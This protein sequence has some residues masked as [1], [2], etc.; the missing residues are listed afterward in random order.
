MEF[1]KFVV[2]LIIIAKGDKFF[3]LL[4]FFAIV[5]TSF[6]QNTNGFLREVY[7]GI[8]G[9]AISDLTN[10]PSFPSS[11]S[12][13]DLLT[14]YFEAPTDWNDN[15]G[16]RVR[17]LII[18][19]MTG[20]YIFWIASDD[21]SQ[22][23]LS[24]D[25]NP[26]NKRLIASVNSWTSSREWTKEAN[27]QS[28]PIRL[29][30]GVRYYIEALQKE[31][32]GGDN[33]AVGWQ[34][35]DGTLERPIP[36]TRAIPY[37]LGPPVITQQ[38]KNTS[39][40]EGGVAT[41]SIQLARYIGMAFQWYRDGQPI[42]GANSYTYFF[43][44]VAM[45]DN[46]STY[47]CIVSNIFGGATSQVARLTVLADTTPPTIVSA[48][49][50]G[51]LTI[52]AVYFS[53]PVEAISATNAA[54]YVLNREAQV[55]S[56]RFGMNESSIILTTT[57]LTPRLT[58][59]LTVNN[60]RDRAAVP[61]TIARDSRVYFKIDYTPLEYYRAIPQI[62]PI[63]PSSRRSPIVISEVMYNPAQRADG[64]NL[65][66]IEI[67]NSQPWFEEIGGWKVMGSVEFTFPE[68]TIIQGNSF[69][70]IAANPSD[71][72]LVYNITNVFGPF[73]GN[74]TLPN[75][76]GVLQIRN[77]RNAVM[78]EMKYSDK[79]PYPCSADGAGH[80]LV[81]SNPSFGERDPRA[82]GQSQ[83]IGGSPG[84]NEPTV[85]NPYATVMINELYIDQFLN[86]Y[87]ELFNY[88]S[89]SVSLAGCILTDDPSTN[90]F[91]IP[92]N[93]IIRAYSFVKF[94]AAQLGFSLN[95]QGGKV[96][97]KNPSNTRVIDS[98]RYDGLEPGVPIGRFPDGARE[99]SRLKYD[100]P[101]TNNAPIL[102]SDIVINEIMY[103][104][105]T[106][107]KDEEY[108]EIYNN[109]SNAVNIGKWRL[110]GGITY[111]FPANA[112]IPPNGYFVV[113]RNVD[114]LL[115]TH[116]GLSRSI[117]FGDFDGSLSNEGDTITLDKPVVIAITNE[118]GGSPI[119]TTLHVVVDEVSYKPGGRWGK[120]SN[121]GGSSLERIDPRADGRWAYNWA[122]SDESQKSQWVTVEYTGV[123]DN[124]NGDSSALHIILM[125]PGECLV[126]NVEVL[127]N[128][129]NLVPNP[130]FDT[131]AAGWFFEGTHSYS[132]YQANGGV[133]GSGCLHVRATERGDTGANRILAPLTSGISA[134]ATATLRAKVRWLKGCGQ[135]LLRLKGNW[136]EA[137]GD[138]IATTDF[139]T[140]GKPNSRLVQNAGPAISDVS[141]Y[142]PVPAANQS[143]TVYA[144]VQDPD[145]LAALLLQYRVD[146]STNFIPLSMVNR[147]AGWYSATI[148]GQ[149]SGT[150]VAF[151]INA[152]DANLQYQEQSFF[153]KEAPE[154]ECLIR[155][156]DP[157]VNG[158]LGVY[159]FWISQ[160]T[161]NRWISRE[162][163]SNDPLDITFIYG[164]N[165]VI[166]N[167]G[168]E[169][170]GSPYHSPGYN[171]PI[172]NNCDYVITFPEDDRLL[173]ET[174]INLLQPGNGGGDSTLQAEQ[175]AYWIAAKMG[176]PI[177][178][179]R[180]V[181][182]FV[183]GVR[184]GMLFEDA[185]QP[186]RD[187]VEEW[188]PEDSKGDLH[189][190][191]LWFEFDDYAS[192]FSAVGANLGNYLTTG[193]QK[194]LARYRW[195]WSKRAFGNDGNNYTN[196][197]ALVDTVNTTAS[198][199]AYTRKIQSVI[200]VEQ[201]YKTH[202][203]EHIVGNNDSYSYGGGQNMYAYK[204]QRGLWNLLIWDIDFAFFAQ[205]PTSDLFGIGGRQSGPV[206]SHPPFARIYWQALIQAA[207]GPLQSSQADSILDARYNAFVADGISPSNPQ[208]I[209]NFIAARRNYILG[210]VQSNTFP[211]AITSNN[212]NGFSTNRNLVV[213]SGTAPLDVRTIAVNGIP[214]DA[215]WTTLSNWTI[216]AHLSPGVN[217]LN[218][219][220][221]DKSGNP[222]QSATAS[223]AIEYT[224]VDEPPKGNIVINEIMYNPVVP[225][226]SYIEVYNRS[227]N[228]AFD[229]SD[230]R[231]EGVD[232]TFDP[233]TIIEPNSY[234]VVVKDAA[235]FTSIY[236][237]SIPIAGEFAGSLN[238]SGETIRLIQPGNSNQTDVV[239]AA[240]TYGSSPPWYEAAN[241]LGSS[242][243]LI[244]PAQD[245]SRVANWGAAFV[246]T[247]ATA[248]MLVSMT[249]VWKYNQTG[250]L[251]GAGWE[252]PNYDDSSWASGAALLYVENAALPAQKNTPLT[253]GR[254]TYYFRKS[255][256]FNGNPSAVSLRL[257][258][259]IDDGA[260]IYLNGNRIYS[261]WMPGG[262]ITYSTFASSAVGDATLEGPIDLP[263]TYLQRGVNVIAV[264]VHQV[265]SGS[266]DIVFG[267]SLETKPGSVALATPGAANSIR[268]ALPQFPPIWLNEIQP[269]NLN[270]IVD[271][272]N[273]R[274][275]WVELYN[276]GTN[277]ISLNGFYL[278]D[279]LTNLTK[280]AFPS[281][282]AIQ[283]GGFLIVFL[284]G[285]SAES[286]ATNLHT[287]FRI[288]ETNGI[289]LLSGVYAGATNLI[290]YLDW[291]LPGPDRTYGS[292][293]EGTAA[294]RRMFY[295]PTPG[296]SNS[297]L[298]PPITVFI[299]EWMVDNTLT[300]A[301]PVDN[302]YEDWF[303]I[304]NP[305]PTPINLAGYYL[306]DS[307]TQSNQFL[308]PNGYVIPPNGFLL[309][310]ADGEPN[311]N[312]PT[313]PALH[314]SFKLASSGEAIG[315]F[316]PDGTLV[317]GVVFGQQTPDVSQGRFPDG[318]SQITAFTNPTPASPNLIIE[319]NLPP[320]IE[321]IGNKTI[322][323]GETLVVQVRVSDPNKTRQNL[324]FSLAP[325][326][327]EGATI[328]PT[329]GIFVWTPTEIFGGASYQ[330]TVRV[331]DDGEPPLSATDTF[332]ISV[333]KTNS[334][335]LLGIP[336][337]RVVNEGETL[338]FVATA[339]DLDLP[340]QRLTFSLDNDA[341]QG[342]SIDPR[343]GL[344]LW[345]P[346]ESQGPG[347]YSFYIYLTDDGEPPMSDVRRI[348]VTV[349]EVN[350]APYFTTNMNIVTHSGCVFDFP[351]SA[352]D[353]DYPP[354][355]LTYSL[356][357][358]A[359]AGA[360]VDQNGKFKWQPGAE[361]KNTTN[362]F[363]VA[364]TDDG[365]PQLGAT[366]S[367]TI[368]ILD[369]L[370]IK[371]D[372]ESNSIWVNTV[373]GR[374]YLLQFKD[375]FSQ[376]H[377]NNASDEVLATGTNLLFRIEDL[378]SMG[379]FYRV[380]SPR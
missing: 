150:I 60:V 294:G 30:N 360:S 168:G 244:D 190:V 354:N 261:V 315:L 62:E 9:T 207:N 198:G 268:A 82:W 49:S 247:N 143:V 56:A 331:T 130:N 86:S 34:L 346:A 93:T 61:N 36:A 213:L 113:A 121:G 21:N 11:P 304:Y 153:P 53:E 255:F 65:E 144:R 176:L 5:Q 191:Q 77:N 227:T 260:V 106:G 292:L 145:G 26:A 184:R 17:G 220:G 297:P 85:S 57:P 210:L 140:P 81:L 350:S 35:P 161:M 287:S 131:D 105:P 239:I 215:V 306:S 188:Y 134:G 160:K 254:L 92:S 234:L 328:D 237:S 174:E 236:G 364:V 146:P 270:G 115:S 54:N 97:L 286:T 232:F 330:V 349:N 283:P 356:I 42:S 51:D 25:D 119:Q 231:I 284:D 274:E 111:T 199:E 324:F 133:N 332:S 162:K 70:V 195:T 74:T 369:E 181:H 196:L 68:G 48:G 193:G 125:G 334:Q 352:T 376:I 45:S 100:T 351:L 28:A 41:F 139:G 301:D 296:A 250:D 233:G 67:Y 355:K 152:L 148:P 377:W 3:A 322:V 22:L 214:Y 6:S 159:R 226:S 251:T 72:R 266:S 202:V 343:T 87:I 98:L 37:G 149:A 277:T 338:S 291:N 314:T 326:A 212:G 171:S 311:Q 170:S 357:E 235:V 302:D 122:D 31:G 288:N 257:Y 323:E 333:E 19:P 217:Q 183:N 2:R 118:Y 310:W 242:L 379:R 66:F 8:N 258:T 33:L 279:N 135:I 278:S 89:Q 80:S 238:N 243:Q 265:S 298:V 218:L 345:T 373:P 223:I 366:N 321:P 16:T 39:V 154:R 75:D 371:L 102:I 117:L 300:L 358:G 204:P 205:G 347:I 336:G 27:Q 264:E 175:Q 282:A 344:F 187:F 15:Y 94:D 337:N 285:E 132:S 339:T 359:S 374:Y 353:P 185:Q 88:H 24:T 63:G 1:V 112:I 13:E 172:G 319:P 155:W 241:G 246:D 156:G 305:S 73:Y 101:N 289:L 206:N 316:A 129:N 44:P 29:T 262:T 7:T 230:W 329:T 55:L 249:D 271:N 197:F 167:A 79:P 189:K 267:M 136:L 141:H 307:L 20:N 58:Y 281:A 83:L 78:F 90:K 109:S 91:I 40:V 365:S 157:V 127:Y 253:L 177:C 362:T 367:F 164:T 151:Y 335:P 158:K 348:T 280:W 186:N 295:I 308:I 317:D 252:Q 245:N 194:K 110:R 211:F 340:P 224:G 95:P 179:R 201:W 64:K 269:L 203:V 273:E 47:Y 10:S 341:P 221:Y 52:V 107:N 342:A 275:P 303:E 370:R 147:G 228:N 123:L 208:S 165:R 128:G 312:S 137:P 361:F 163:M 313:N 293:P 229:L 320:V 69:I 43:S 120:W 290:D 372:L 46:G 375:K 182:L 103:D 12:L 380:I 219:Q 222:V 84:T 272:F 276:C 76:S 169:Y 18:P 14:N 59:T 363:V 240:V 299:N 259:V 108:V 180:S 192:S 368:I 116:P 23:F 327:P 166:Y 126:D 263:S 318:A 200:D 114:R 325:G 216:R 256:V 138:I 71:F 209:K 50:L 142:P 309:V 124:G 4:L 38:P 378:S 32:G 96:I 178:Y 248:Q 104:P 173:G 225:R 99:F